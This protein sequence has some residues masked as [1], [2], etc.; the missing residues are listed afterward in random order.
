MS[1]SL[2]NS[3]QCTRSV[4]TCDWSSHFLNHCSLLMFPTY[5]ESSL[6]FSFLSLNQ[7]L[8]A[9]LYRYNLILTS[10][11]GLHCCSNWKPVY[12]ANPYMEPIC[13]RFINFTMVDVFRTLAFYYHFHQSSFIFLCVGKQCVSSP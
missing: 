3:R 5:A 7:F 12:L 2:L 11:L 13:S 9:I 10:F 4:Y 1:N 8:P 6:F